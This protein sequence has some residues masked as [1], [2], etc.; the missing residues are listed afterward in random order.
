MYNKSTLKSSFLFLRKIL[1]LKIQINRVVN[2]NANN[3]L[4]LTQIQTNQFNL[5][6]NDYRYIEISSLIH[7]IYKH[8]LFKFTFG[9]VQKLVKHHEAM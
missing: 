1:L 5:N 9:I 4:H 7:F 6:I 8:N 3:R 2:L